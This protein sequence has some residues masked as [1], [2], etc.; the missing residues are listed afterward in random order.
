MPERLGQCRFHLSMQRHELWRNFVSAWV[1]WGIVQNSEVVVHLNR[2]GSNIFTSSKTVEQQHGLG[3]V[4]VSEAPDLSV[5][6]WIS[7][8]G[9][10]HIQL[11]HSTIRQY[12]FKPHTGQSG[13]CYSSQSTGECN[14]I[15]LD[16]KLKYKIKIAVSVSSLNYLPRRSFKKKIPQWP[17]N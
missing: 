1:G 8:S 15:L 6:W 4:L 14:T 7:A 16:A 5:Q 3:L 10:H 11:R 12:V 2:S 13:K 17:Q 9:S